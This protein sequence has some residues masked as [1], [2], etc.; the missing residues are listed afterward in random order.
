MNEVCWFRI[1]GVPLLFVTSSFGRL[2]K[3]DPC[4]SNLER[5]DFVRILINTQYMEQ[6]QIMCFLNLIQILLIMFLL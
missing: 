2:L 4:T 3:I 6:K 1:Y 5:L